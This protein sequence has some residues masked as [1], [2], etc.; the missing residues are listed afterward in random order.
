MEND[1]LSFILFVFDFFYVIKF[2]DPQFGCRFFSLKIFKPVFLKNSQSPTFRYKL[3]YVIP[4]YITFRHGFGVDSKA[5]LNNFRWV[6]FKIVL[7][8]F[9]KFSILR[10]WSFLQSPEESLM[11]M[12][13]I[14]QKVDKNLKLDKKSKIWQKKFEIRQN[15]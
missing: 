2:W 8:R 1:N 9:E 13:Y 5:V 4:E 11:P 10:F 3:L 12:N 14:F 15:T 7:G 6:W